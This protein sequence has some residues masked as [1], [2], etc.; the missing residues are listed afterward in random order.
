MNFLESW[1]VVCTGSF[2]GKDK[3]MNPVDFVGMWINVEKVEAVERSM[4]LREGSIP[5]QRIERE[6]LMIESWNDM[7]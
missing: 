7:A 1:C 2:G 3:G 4:V 5:I 6:V